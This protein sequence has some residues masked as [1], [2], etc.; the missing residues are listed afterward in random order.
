MGTDLPMTDAGESRT[1]ART[2]FTAGSISKTLP[3]LVQIDGY[4]ARG[5]SGSPIFDRTGRVIS[6]LYGGQP[7]S[8]GRIVLSVPSTLALDLLESQQ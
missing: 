8:G 2:T 4:G 7:G 6:I 5:A 3:D 1:V